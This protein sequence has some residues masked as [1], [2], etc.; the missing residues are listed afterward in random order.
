MP[1]RWPPSEIGWRSLP[2]T[3]P[4]HIPHAR[5]Q[6]VLF[7]TAWENAIGVPSADGQG[8]RGVQVV[9]VQADPSELPRVFQPN[10]PN[11]DDDGFVTMPNVKL[12]NEMVD[13]ITASRSYEANLKS[14]RM[15][16][17]MVEQALSL[18]RGL[19]S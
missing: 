2:T 10:H 4:T 5:R 17:R 16:R 12:P 14:L 15:F 13:L 19:G 3:S 7:A 1:P 18:L 6:Q 9:G 11:A 8:Y